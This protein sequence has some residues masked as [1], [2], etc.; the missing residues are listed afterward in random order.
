MKHWLC[1][2][3]FAVSVVLGGAFALQSCDDDMLTG[4]PSWLG[5]SIYERLQED[6]N[7]QTTLRLIDDLGQHDVLSQT[8]SKT[9]FAANDESFAKWF[10][11][12]TWGVRSYEQ[13]STAQKKLLLNSSM[14]N[15]AYLIELLSNVSGNPPEKGMCMR[16]ETAT[17]IYDSV[18]VMKP[19]DMPA[20][21]AW[22]QHRDK[23]GGI[24]IFK[25][26]TSAPMIHF[27]PAFMRYYKITDEDL[28]ILTNGGATSIEEAWVNGKRV[29][30]RDITCKN[31]YVHK[32]DD[33]IEP[34]SNMAEILRQTEETSGWSKLIDRFSAPYYDETG[35]REYNRLY[36]NEDSVFTLRYFSDTSIEGGTNTRPDGSKVDATLVFDPGWNQYMYTNTMGQ[37]LHY[38]AAAMIVPNNEALNEWWER[39]VLRER[40][41]TW[42][43]VP[44]GVL[45]ELLNVNMLE[46]FSDKVPS[47]FNNI[48][49]DAKI[50]LG[51]T[52]DNVKKCYI[53]CNGVVYVVDKVFPPSAYS[54]VAF[55]ALI[56]SNEDTRIIYWAIDNLDFKPY[57]NSMDSYY[58][59][60][61]PTDNAMLCY[62]DP[63]NYG[64]TAQTLL[65]FTY[66]DDNKTVAAERYACTVAD[67]GTVTVG[68]RLQANVPSTIISNRLQD[69]MDQLIIV[70][71]VE[72]GYSYYKSKGGTYVNVKEP[73]VSN[74][75]TVS[76][77]WQLDKGTGI[78]VDEIHDMSIDGNGKTYE[79]N[80]QVPL[81]ASKSVYATLKDHSEYQ[82]FLNLLDGGD[83]ESPK[84]NLL[85]SNMSNKY[86]CAGSTNGNL[87]MR[88]FQNYNYTVYIPTNEAIR[89]LIDR[90]LLPTWDDFD[91]QYEIYDDDR[92]SSDDRTKARWACDWIR[93]RIIGFVSY[94]IQDNSVLVGG[95]PSKDSHGDIVLAPSYETMKQNP[96]NNRFYSVNLS[97]TTNGISV[98]D[99]LG[100]T[101]KVQ[102]TQGLYNNICREYW[103]SGTGNSRLIYMASD[104]V[105]HQIDGVLQYDD[106]LN[107]SWKDQL[108]ADW[109][110]YLR[111]SNNN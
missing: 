12:N 1:R 30:E 21:Q 51:I 67:D 69:L 22:D 35:T 97:L 10:E 34:L 14:V 98:T 53:G 102:T 4:Q 11:N 9:L 46:N 94:H 73:G 70:G 82:E 78:L 87:N 96:S 65:R 49:N 6:G 31:G 37:D 36:N 62:L 5:N 80:T 44:D 3:G 33:V 101:R 90:G 56:R 74:R 28:S 41:G 27:L 79:L 93:D 95:E 81:G 104:A 24:V 91:A 85:I 109:N 55:P 40:Y 2:P 8:G 86:N 29:G 105:V 25:D 47:K 64:E 54:S 59:F 103:F 77:G 17:S 15:N 45:A 18:Y 88:L 50:E 71:D 63:I 110:E 107:K 43:N 99:Q 57:L 20:T 7:Y 32:V 75:M 72:D 100:Q 13:L 48:L 60:F 108:E 84:L 83:P 26:A 92:T 42:D 61:M 38:D 106:S 111:E 58:S 52:K 66:D 23:Q 19:E 89:D 76:G 39:S 68:T 16:R